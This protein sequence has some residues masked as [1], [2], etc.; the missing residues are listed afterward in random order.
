M[1]NEPHNHLLS[2]PPDGEVLD[3]IAILKAC[4][5][6]AIAELKQAGELL[7]NQGLL[8][9]LLPLLEAKTA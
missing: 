4:I 8:I 3:D 6:S 5:A 1:A 7:P 9:N 2:S